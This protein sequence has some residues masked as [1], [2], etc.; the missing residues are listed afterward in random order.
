MKST[1]WARKKADARK[2]QPYLLLKVSFKPNEQSDAR[3]GY[4]MA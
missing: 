4:A 1:R 3:I 2:H